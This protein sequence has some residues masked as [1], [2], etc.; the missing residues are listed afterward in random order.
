M[1][2][3]NARPQ[4]VGRDH[5]RKRSRGSDDPL[6]A[7]YQQTMRV[8]LADLLTSLEPVPQDQGLGMVTVPPKRPSL[9][10][11]TKIWDLAI[12]LGRELGSAID[13]TP[14]TGAA[15]AGSRGIPRPRKVSYGD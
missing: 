4:D 8:E 1:M 3:D 13:P 7:R 15:G 14:T 6:L 12:K 9:A 2:T 5:G 11:R 10:E